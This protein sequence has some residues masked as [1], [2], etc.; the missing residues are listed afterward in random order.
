MLIPWEE[1][2]R[3]EDKVWEGTTEEVG[4]RGMPRSLLPP[5]YLGYSSIGWIVND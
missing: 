1:K 3:E 5:L 2:K 4:F